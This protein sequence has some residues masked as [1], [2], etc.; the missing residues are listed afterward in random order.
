MNPNKD[1]YDLLV[2][3]ENRCEPAFEELADA[4]AQLRLSPDAAAVLEVVCLHLFEQRHSDLVNDVTDHF[5]S[6]ILNNPV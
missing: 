1:E 4:L 3:V 2:A 6:E 5:A